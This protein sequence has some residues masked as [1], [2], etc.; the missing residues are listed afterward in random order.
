MEEKLDVM[1]NK[2]W[3]MQ[4]QSQNSVILILGEIYVNTLHI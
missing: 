2:K 1:L 4:D 3:R